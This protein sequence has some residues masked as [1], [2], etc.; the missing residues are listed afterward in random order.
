MN[1]VVLVASGRAVH[2]LAA[3]EGRHAVDTHEDD[4]GNSRLDQTV[5]PLVKVL[6]DGEA[7]CLNRALSA[8]ALGLLVD[9]GE[10][11][12][13]TRVTRDVNYRAQVPALMELLRIL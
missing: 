13:M 11:P 10:R 3:A 8:V 7:A 2:V 5:E 1:H 9:G 4:L 12:G 6:R